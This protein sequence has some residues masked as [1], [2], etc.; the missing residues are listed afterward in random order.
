MPKIPFVL[1]LALAGCETYGASS[2][3]Y[4]YGP[5]PAYGYYDYG[6]RGYDSGYG[7]GRYNQRDR[8]GQRERY[9]QPTQMQPRQV[10]PPPSATQN[11]KA[12]ENL[13]FRPN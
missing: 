6:S 3:G 9:N 7:A 4:G 11:Q 8:Y 13:G 2:G 12:L 1:L 10:A 5:P